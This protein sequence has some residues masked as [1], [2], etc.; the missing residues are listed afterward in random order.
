MLRDSSIQRIAIAALVIVSPIASSPPV[1]AQ[2][3]PIAA[4][5]ELTLESLYHPQLKVDFDGELPTTH[6]IDGTPNQLLVKRDETWNQL[7]LETG[8]ESVWPVVRQLSD[9]LAAL[10][11]VDAAQ[12]TSAA[13][14]AV[15][16]LRAGSDTVLIRIGKS[17]AI[18]SATGQTP[19]CARWLTRDAAAWRDATLDPSSRR[20]AY[21]H[22]GDLFILDATTGQQL[23]LTNDGSET[24]LDGLLDWTYQEEIFGRGNFR[25]FW[26]SPDGD[27]LAMLRIDISAIE[28][29]TLPSAA[30]ARGSGE[31]SRYP[32]AGDPIPHAALLVWDLRSLDSGHLPPPR[33]IAQSSA[34]QE[35]IITGVWWNPH[36]PALLFCI[37]DRKQTW[38]E[39]RSLDVSSL[40]NG[41]DG[42]TVVLREESPAWVEPPSPPGFLPDGNLIWRSE[43]PTGR[44]RLY[45]LS[46][47]GQRVS[48]LTPENFDARDFWTS[49][50]GDFLIVTGDAEGRTVNQQAYRVAIGSGSRDFTSQ[51]FNLNRLTDATGWH[52]IT[53]SP[54]CSWF[55]D[56]H[57]TASSPP[58]MSIRSTSGPDSHDLV[59]TKLRLAGKLIEPEFFR[60][61]TADGI[62]LPAMLVRPA[63]A[64]GQRIP[65]VV[66]VYG[67]P[68][69]PKVVNRWS[70]QTLDRELLARQGIATLV[71]DNR[72][73]AGR[74]LADTWSIQGRVGEIEFQDLMTGVEWLRQQDWADPDRLAIRGWSF[75]GFLTLYAMTHSEAFVAGIAGGSVTDWKEYDAFYTERYMGLPS[76]NEEGYQATAPVRTADQ[77]HGVVM[78]IHGEADDNVHPSGTL[79]M[80]KALQEAGK[81][82][83]LM[84]YPDQA[85]AVRQ[86][87]QLWHLSQMTDKFLLDQLRPGN[88]QLRPGNSQLRPGNSQLRPGN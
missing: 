5:T 72:S 59:Q 66:E 87:N 32:K 2:E 80:A 26:F 83:R 36:Q 58:A 71:L 25:A 13:I 51:D 67:G 33:T 16:S 73:S 48:P 35:R 38:R 81:E 47:G 84:L 82:F 85:H 44:T 70:L 19:P 28:P 79:R 39:L 18:A 22:D 14:G 8:S 69:A 46:S 21:T 65:V 57:S 55:V 31:R 24:L 45:H 76:E 10:E 52:A 75:G 34:H 68:Q 15:P 20:V 64:A 88:S 4:P 56:S 54:D 29:Y 43:L 86:P 77:M 9:N 40:V 37:S 53:P 41:Q 12:A 63:S 30:S 27:W 1:M 23:Q 60:I 17:L 78:L 74:G 6:W 42:A 61:A 11:G 7:N 49:P 50:A 62:S 3:S